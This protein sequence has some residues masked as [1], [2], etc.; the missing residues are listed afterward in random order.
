MMWVVRCTLVTA[1]YSCN[2]LCAHMTAWDNT[3]VAAA[4]HMLK[5]LKYMR[6]EVHVCGFTSVCVSIGSL[7]K[8]FA[9]PTLRVTTLV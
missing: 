7:C 6:D 4:T 2:V 1:K 3:Y 5:Y 8:Y 9:T